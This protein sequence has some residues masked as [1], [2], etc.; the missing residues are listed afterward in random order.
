MGPGGLRP[1]TPRSV[2]SKAA[3]DEVEEGVVAVGRVGDQHGRRQSA[4]AALEAGIE[5]A[6]SRGCRS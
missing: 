1:L 3:V 4:L 2:R 5:A 6:H